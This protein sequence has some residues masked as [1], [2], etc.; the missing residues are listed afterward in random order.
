MQPEDE[1]E[2]GS[3]C[4]VQPRGKHV[5]GYEIFG[6]YLDDDMDFV[7]RR[8]TGSVLESTN[9]CQKSMPF[10][11]ITQRVLDPGTPVIVIHPPIQVDSKKARGRMAMKPNTRI[12]EVLTPETGKTYWVKMG[13]LRIVK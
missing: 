2:V 9:S 3:L 4:T 7:T 6:A 1:M 10:L 11:A 12:C 5:L 8:T 13:L